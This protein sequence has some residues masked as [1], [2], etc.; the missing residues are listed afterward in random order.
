MSSAG[1]APEHERRPTLAGAV[2]AVLLGLV[3][4]VV[5]AE[6]ILRIAMPHWDEFTSGRFMRQ[7]AVPGHGT[8]SVGRP[9]FDGWFAQNNGDFRVRIRL[10]QAGLRNPEPLD[11]ADGRIWVVGDSMTFGW[12]VAHEEMYSSVVARAS[13]R[14][15][16]NLA[17]PGTDVCGYQALAARMPNGV[18]PSA[19]VVGL[20]IENDVAVYRCA[21]SG[22]AENPPG[23][24]PT[25]GFSFLDLKVFL[26]ANSALYNVMTQSLKRIPALNEFLIKLGLV[27]RP[28]HY[29]RSLTP[30]EIAAA[31]ESTVAEIDR[32]R[33]MFPAG[34][35]FAVLLIPAR[36]D[37]RDGD[38]FYVSQ[39]QALRRALKKR[40]ITAI[41]P[42]KAF[43]AAGFTAT[44][45]AHDGHW[46]PR[47]HEI[48]GR[49]VGEWA[50]RTL[51][52]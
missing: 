42:R 21:A 18:R 38:A 49:A 4:L 25:D 2:L 41:D 48:A 19:V 32:L 31:A 45:F 47:G 12:G 46:S 37:I 34:M 52:R 9:G 50:R 14:P 13:A 6:A 22:N 27:A 5:V 3:V 15:T 17:S 33:A 36:F 8:V 7:E 20:V 26:T 51:A 11:G 30:E 28:H 44:H 1:A 39:R 43:R 16:Y 10:N 35:P 40:A 23:A 24:A 29:R